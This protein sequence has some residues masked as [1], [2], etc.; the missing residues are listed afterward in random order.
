MWA[1]RLKSE[2]LVCCSWADVCVANCTRARYCL[3]QYCGFRPTSPE[4]QSAILLN[5]IVGKCVQA[6]CAVG[7]RE[8]AIGDAL[9]QSDGASTA[10]RVP[11]AC[12][13]HLV[14]LPSHVAP[15][16]IPPW[17]FAL[18]VVQHLRDPSVG[19]VPMGC[20]R[21]RCRPYRST[22]TAKPARRL[23]TLLPL[24]IQSAQ[25]M[26]WR[27]MMHDCNLGVCACESSTPK[28]CVLHRS[29]ISS[30]PGFQRCSTHHE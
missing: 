6:L 11:P 17:L 9:Q 24:T 18:R 12:T 19:R 22:T 2:F 14:P 27:I 5:D 13:E 3:P 15:L 23:P 30:H 4:N 20:L 7:A 26:Q 8:S 29:D 21:T 10:A 25:I 1:P 16:M 28:A